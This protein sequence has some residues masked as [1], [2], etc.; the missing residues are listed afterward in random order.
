M[1]V[2]DIDDWPGTFSINEGGGVP[3][4][5][6]QITIGDVRLALPKSVSFLGKFDGSK[7]C[8]CCIVV[9]DQNVTPPIFGKPRSWTFVPVL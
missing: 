5:A 9:P 4:H 8:L 7:L 6:S 2:R 1:K 3:I